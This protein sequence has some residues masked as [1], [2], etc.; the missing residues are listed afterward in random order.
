MAWDDFL[1]TAED[2]RDNATDIYD[3]LQSTANDTLV[4]VGAPP[5]GNQTPLQLAQGLYGAVVPQAQPASGKNAVLLSPSTS[6]GNMA[7]AMKLSPAILALGAV[8]VYYFFFMK[9][10]R[11]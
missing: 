2:Y 9:K 8:A 5:L 1:A 7:T 3:H 4:A 6:T 11:A 10:G